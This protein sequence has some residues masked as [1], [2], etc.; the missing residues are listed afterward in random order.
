MKSLEIFMQISRS[1]TLFR[2]ESLLWHLKPHHI[3]N[4]PDPT[5][6]HHLIYWL[7]FSIFS[8]SISFCLTPFPSFFF[9]SVHFL[10]VTKHLL[11]KKWND[12]AWSR[13]T[14]V[15]A[16]I[17]KHSPEREMRLKQSIFR[18]FSQL[19]LSKTECR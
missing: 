10:V 7:K 1:K 5:W 8:F 9:L 14:K 11:W 4:K 15:R 3:W 12:S 17:H 13:V 19:F 18:K 16:N 2:C 6:C